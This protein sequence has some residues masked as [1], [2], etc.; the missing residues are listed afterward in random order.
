M[1]RVLAFVKNNDED[2]GM[3]PADKTFGI[4]LLSALMIKVNKVKNYR[5]L[6]QY[7]KSVNMN[8]EYAEMFNEVCG[9]VTDTLYILFEEYNTLQDDE[10]DAQNVFGQEEAVNQGL[11]KLAKNSHLV[12]VIIKFTIIAIENLLPLTYNFRKY[13]MSLQEKEHMSG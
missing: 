10:N 3:S 6:D 13:E 11:N 9:A 2:V 12:S 1:E 7:D 5:K 4:S 8:R